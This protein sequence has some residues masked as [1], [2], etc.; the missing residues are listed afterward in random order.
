M[1]SVQA[2]PAVAQGF[3]KTNWV[4]MVSL[5]GAQL[6]HL[7]YDHRFMTQITSSAIWNG[8]SPDGYVGMLN[9][10]NT[11]ARTSQR[12][13]EKMVRIFAVRLVSF[14]RLGQGTIEYMPYPTLAH[15][16]AH[17]GE[18]SPHLCGAPC[19]VP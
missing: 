14:P 9:R 8:P 19:V 7:R 4:L 13:Q 16:A 3:G 18:D 5:C 15:L 10:T 6:K 2:C 12:T 1:C 17:A 11:A